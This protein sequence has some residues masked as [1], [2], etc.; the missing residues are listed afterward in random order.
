MKVQS[1]K[2]PGKIYLYGR[3]SKEDEQQ[4][5]SNSIVNQRDYLVAHAKAEGYENY[6]FIFDDGFSGADFERPSFKRMIEE[7]EAGKVAKVIVKDMS[8]FGRDYLKVGFF[9]E[10]LFVDKNVH[11]KAVADNVDNMQGNNDIVPVMNLFNEWHVKNTSDKIRTVKQAQGKA[12]I[13][14]TVYPKYGYRKSPDDKKQ[15]IIDDE[16]AAVVRR[17]FTMFVGGINPAQIAATL[18][19]ERIL[20]PSAY[21]EI[22]GINKAPQ[23]CKEPC[24][25]HTTTIHKMLDTREYIG[26]TVN[27]KTFTRSYKDKRSK[28]NPVENQMIFEG[29]HPAIIEK[30][31]WELVRKLREHKHRPTRHGNVGL[32]TGIAYCSDCEEKLYYLTREI[33]NKA[34]TKSRLDGAYSCSSYRK[35]TQYQRK[36]GEGCTAHYIR[37]EVLAELV[38]EELRELLRFVDKNESR[39][40]KMIM[41]KSMA[42]QNKA[43][44]LKKQSSQKMQ[45]R[46]GELDTLIERIYEDNVSGKIS[47]ERF[48]K[49]LAKYETE[50]A[51]L[52]EK[53]TLFQ[54]ELAELESQ[55]ANVE[56]FMRKVRKYTS[57]IET[58]TPAIVREFVDKIIVHEPINPRK[59]R[60]QKVEIIYNDVGVVPCLSEKVGA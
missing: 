3:L 57:A 22:N 10:V 44:V 19:A 45:L 26:D 12:G 17:V 16:S 8:R 48:A 1:Q 27:F 11:F 49:L 60:V 46:I 55:S 31:V 18:T 14:L 15:W 42:E 29:T 39:F 37:E 30:D 4:G 54:A 50:Q 7:V 28:A 23:K 53:S 32:F 40:A 20:C 59:N 21:K 36:N 56:R 24:H 13:K 41:D 58:L 35:Q 6:E 47:D 2:S 25:W 38:L 5:E 33:W 43:L 34:R 52:V 9:T 51:K